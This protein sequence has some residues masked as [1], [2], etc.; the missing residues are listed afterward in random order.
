MAKN[1]LPGGVGKKI[2]EALKRQAEADITLL[3]E[4]SGN[5]SNSVPLTE[6]DDISN[7]QQASLNEQIIEEDELSAVLPEG[8]YQEKQNT[9]AIL[10]SESL[11]EEESVTEQ[12]VE[13][14]EEQLPVQ[15]EQTFAFQQEMEQSAQEVNSFSFNET[16]REVQV[17]PLT[18]GKVSIP[19]N[20]L[21]LRNLISTLPV[22]VTKQTGAQI[23]RQTLEA[24]GLPI[25][26]V[27]KEAQDVQEQLN[28]STRECMLK[29]QE[30]KTN[31]LQLEQSVQD[32]QRN[33]T[34]INDLVSL[35]LLT[36]KNN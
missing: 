26:S 30:Y 2:V 21:V 35:F 32:Y 36:D 18:T 13:Q 9:E 10:S 12:T 5:L 11:I 6:I 20:V 22:G 15:E 34:Q 27:L 16:Q 29:I 14:Q 3:D 28:M 1:Q 23:I 7:M 31:I 25:N 17:Q 4:E 33:I 19:A 8:I 24:M